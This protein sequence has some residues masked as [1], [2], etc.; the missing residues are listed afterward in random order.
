[1]DN[2]EP[3]I[4]GEWIAT[5]LAEFDRR[6]TRAFRT[7]EARA[8]A[9]GTAI[10]A[11]DRE[12]ATLT[13]ET[14]RRKFPDAGLISEEEK[15]PYLPGA[16]YQWVLDPI[17]GTA[18][19]ARGYPVWG[20]GLGL[21]RNR[22]PLQGCLRFPMLGETYLCSGGAILINGEKLDPP[23]PHGLRDLEN[24]LIGSGLHGVVPLE[25]L[26]D[27]K[28]RNLGSNLYHLVALAAGRAEAM[29]S[30]QAYIWDLVPALPFTRARGYVERYLDGAPFSLHDLFRGDPP[31]FKLPHPL[32]IGAKEWVDRIVDLLR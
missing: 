7:V 8:K 20:L 32:V 23:P 24:L 17:D 12:I 18:S 10:T 4:D 31:T 26:K 29:I 9:D 11:L 30:P 19:F 25:K 27:F 15:T 16:E 13:R 6:A 21:M 22:E 28:L 3:S 14:L 1:M 2:P 5:L